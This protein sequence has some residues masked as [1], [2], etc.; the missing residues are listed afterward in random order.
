MLQLLSQSN[1]GC[2]GMRGKGV[3]RVRGEEIELGLPDDQDKREQERAG[4]SSHIML[5]QSHV[6]FPMTR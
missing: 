4:N 6:L 2:M 3:S 1:K 5:H